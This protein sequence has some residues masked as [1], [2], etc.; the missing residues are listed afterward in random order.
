MKRLRLMLLWINDL[1][2]NFAETFPFKLTKWKVSLNILYL[3]DKFPILEKVVSVSLLCSIPSIGRFLNC[4]LS[5]TSRLNIL[6]EF[7]SERLQLA[8]VDFKSNS[9]TFDFAHF[10]S[11]KVICVMPFE[12][13]ALANFCKIQN[14]NKI[15]II[16]RRVY[17]LLASYHEILKL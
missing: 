15:F 5:L 4:I 1:A 10:A 6:S 9:Q 13:E 14:V 3:L 16:S 12:E 2:V 7:T 8:S 17:K 11:E